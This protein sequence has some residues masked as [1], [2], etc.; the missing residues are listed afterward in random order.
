VSDAVGLLALSQTSVEF[1][2]W[3]G[4]A[5]GA[6]A[7]GLVNQ[8]RVPIVPVVT[9]GT[10]DGNAWL[11]ANAATG[12]LAAGAS[13][14]I[15]ITV[16]P[17]SLAPGRYTGWVAAGGPGVGNGSQVV[18]IGLTVLS[19]GSALPPEVPVSGLA[20]TPAASQGSIL[21]NLASGGA[22]T[23]TTAISGV[24]H[25]WLRV[26]PGQGSVPANGALQLTV[27]ADAT[28][29]GPGLYA[30]TV[31][32][33]FSDGTARSVPVEFFVPAVAAEAPPRGA[34]AV[35]GTGGGPFVAH[36]LSPA[37]SFFARAGRAMLFKIQAENCDGTLASN[38]EVAGQYGGQIF[39]LLPE[40]AGVWSGNWVPR[41]AA[42]QAQLRFTATMIANGQRYTFQMAAAGSVAASP[43][44]V[45]PVVLA[46]VNG[47]APVL[48]APVAPGSWVTIYGANLSSQTAT[49]G[50]I[51][52]PNLLGGVEVSV[53]DL[54][55]PLY[56]VSSGQVNGVLPKALSP[57]VVYQ[58]VI[59]RDGVPSVPLPITVAEVRAGLFTQNQQGTGQAAAV[60]SG[61]VWLAAPSTPVA[62]GGVV[63]V[64]ATGLG[65]VQNAPVDGAPA[66]MAVL[67]RVLNEPVVTVGG[68]PARVLFAGLT[69]G[70]IGLYQ[71]N[72]VIPDDAPTGDGVAIVVTQ[73][74]AV[75][76]AA[77]IAIR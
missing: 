35:C 25:D 52:L 37:P 4:G 32:M 22:L 70:A 48:N 15:E 44:S 27:N 20:L 47:A 57:G 1:V 75:S 12:S 24:N 67:S 53:G 64:Y 39:P 62:R 14:P 38:L 28:K 59:R 3:T 60:L 11:L 9:S 23:F 5:P 45:E 40:S 21:L 56:Y 63:E 61:T 66:S 26:T 73:K 49:A 50:A 76:N 65:A 55:M 10:T 69:P 54:P 6:V 58:L 19:A 41:D 43:V 13:R 34:V 7:V 68:R 2:A 74:G 18:T 30:A 51:P 29:V 42:G 33:G 36:L 17:G 72:V 31:S 8:G 77:M 16:N 71:I 46:V